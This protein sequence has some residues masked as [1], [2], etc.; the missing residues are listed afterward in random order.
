M[1]EIPQLCLRKVAVFV[2]HGGQNSFTEA[3]TTGTPMIPGRTK[4]LRWL[5]FEISS[6]WRPLLGEIRGFLHP[7]LPDQKTKMCSFFCFISPDQSR[8]Q[9]YICF[10]FP[11]DWMAQQFHGC[12]WETFYIFASCGFSW[13]NPTTQLPTK[14]HFF[15]PKPNVT[16]EFYGVSQDC[17][18]RL[19]G[20]TWPSSSGRAPGRGHPSGAPEVSRALGGGGGL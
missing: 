13:K 14:I 16:Q 5:C 6:T 12:C 3:L 2:T 10:S 1:M 17:V 8:K 19:R 7:P 18:P 9:Q 15:F 4:G 11:G 20:S